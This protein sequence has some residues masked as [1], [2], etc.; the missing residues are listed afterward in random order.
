MG[1]LHLLAEWRSRLRLLRAA[2]ADPVSGQ[3]WLDQIRARILS[4][5]LRRYE[6][7]GQP[8]ATPPVALIRAVPSAAPAFCPI[9]RVDGPPPRSGEAIASILNDIRCCNQP[10]VRRRWFLW[11]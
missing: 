4:F 8:E 2:A 1:L 3:A 6:G 5:L 11:G 10:R 7:A 9:V